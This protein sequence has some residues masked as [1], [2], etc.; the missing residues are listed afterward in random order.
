MPIL[1]LVLTVPLIPVLLPIWKPDRLATFYKNAGIGKIGILK[2]EDLEDHPLPQ[3]F[4]DMLGWRELA[5]KSEK[6]YQSLP[7]ICKT[8]YR[9]VLPQLWP[10]RCIE[11]LCFFA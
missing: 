9:Y 6:Y 10:G 2:W 1:A 5:E 8:T 7:D 4:A 3:D 11:I